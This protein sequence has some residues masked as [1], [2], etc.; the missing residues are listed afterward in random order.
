GNIASLE[1]ELMEPRGWELQ[2]EA[3]SSVRTR[4]SLLSKAKDGDIW[5]KGAKKAEVKVTNEDLEAVIIFR[6][7]NRLYDDPPLPEKDDEGD[8]E[9]EGVSTEKAKMG[10]AEEYGERAL[11]RAG[12]KKGLAE[13]VQ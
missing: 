3:D 7:Q 11:A 1:D 6:I 10:L 8:G 5:F 9:D 12:L 13:G 4:N 2:G